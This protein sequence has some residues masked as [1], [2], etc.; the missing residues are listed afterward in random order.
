VDDPKN[1]T[2][3]PSLSP[4]GISKDGKEMVLIWSDAMKNKQGR[5]HTVNYTWNHMKVTI[6][7]K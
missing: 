1:R 2:Y 3:Q 5:S 4:K 6:Q 7:T